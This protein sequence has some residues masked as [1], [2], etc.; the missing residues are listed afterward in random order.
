MEE[1]GGGE[2]K[3]REEMEEDELSQSGRISGRR[4][5]RVEERFCCILWDTQTTGSAYDTAYWSDGEEEK[6]SGP[7]KDDLYYSNLLLPSATRS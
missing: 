7:H 6:F 5:Q 3:R 4:A 1:E 2:E